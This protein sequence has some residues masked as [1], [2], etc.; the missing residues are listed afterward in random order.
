MNRRKTK[1]ICTMGPAVKDLETIKSL[2][3]EGM[4]I[5]RLN[6][7]HGD[8]EYH[9]EMIE[10]LREAS[11]QTSIPVGILLDIKGPEIR[12]G[13]IKDDK[14]ITLVAGNRVTLTTD[15]VEG[16]DKLLNITYKNLPSEI[17][18]GK[19][20]YIADG[21]VDLEVESVHQNQIN[22]LIINGAE[23]GSRKNVNV[24]GIKTSLPAVTEKDIKDIIFG[25]EQNVDFI[26]ASFIRKPSDVKEIRGLID[27]CDSKIS[28]ISKIEDE[29]GLDNIDEIIRVSNG[30]MVARGDLGVQI[31][32]EDI[33][34]VQKRIILKCN[35]ANKPVI[36]ATQMLDSM[37]NNPKPTRAEATDV[38]N[39]IFDGTD[40][41]MLSGETA[42]GKYPV[43]TVKT[44]HEIALNVEK[45]PE[46]IEKR[47]SSIEL[48]QNTNM[49]DTIA[50]ASYEIALNIKADALLTPTL[51]GTTPKL[52][53]RYR[54]IQNIIAVTTSPEV[55]RS[56]LIYWG[57]IPIITELMPDSDTM[58]NNA[59]KVSMDMGYVKNFNKIVI[60]AGIPVNS[61]I[62]LNMIKVHLV[63]NV[64][65]K[66][67]RGYGGIASGRIVKVNNIEE[68]KTLIKGDGN[69][70]MLTRYIDESFKPVLKKIKGYIL[71]EFSSISWEEIH[72]E[73]LEL[74]AIAGALNAMSILEN[75]FSVTMDG[76]EKLVYEGIINIEN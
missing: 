30:I 68:A 58:I 47:R 43:L 8:H 32:M 45:S 3:I 23:F 34:L 29:E 36:V 37:I 38:A 33:P 56:L 6:C 24:V 60:V 15:E 75:N 54:P 69:E 27:I 50:K 10:L 20:I 31:K 57:I 25:V 19:H 72:A 41:I 73:N 1:I 46:Y 40:A 2:L 74:V 42:S 18:P 55:Q 13:R 44:M 64:L 5:A 66:G 11:R 22:C 61:P 65:A 21:L 67:T 76:K 35:Q 7:A 49:A 17:S 26:A 51:H 16:T 63:S 71:E 12:T 62:M 52:I 48:F 28:I 59:I 9:K 53:S 14:K 39:A 4:N 70:I